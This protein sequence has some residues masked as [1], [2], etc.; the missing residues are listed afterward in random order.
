VTVRH[1]T[2]PFIVELAFQR[3]TKGT[4]VFA[5]TDPSAPVQ[6]LCVIKHALGNNP[7]PRITLTIAATAGD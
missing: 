2:A 6:S 4:Y 7:P 5:A 3:S 1:H